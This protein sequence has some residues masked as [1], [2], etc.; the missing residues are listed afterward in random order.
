[1]GKGVGDLYI[2]AECRSLI[3]TYAIEDCT[4][5]WDC[6]S[7]D[8]HFDWQSYMVHTHNSNG[9]TFYRGTGAGAVCTPSDIT[10]P[11]DFEA[12]YTY[13]GGVAYSC[14]VI[15]GGGSLIHDVNNHRTWYY[16]RE[17]A[18][19]FNNTQIEVSETISSGDKIKICRE[20]GVLTLYHN[21]V[22]K[23]TISGYGNYNK[24]ELES[25]NS[26]RSTTIKDLKIKPL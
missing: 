24:V 3:Q 13:I 20:N 9:L 18:T 23:H 11:T 21:N 4:Y 12:E 6:L 5:Y 17:C 19:N 15:I 10:V 7:D 14:G 26:S 8:G 22:L 16:Y 2:K 1:M 25:Y